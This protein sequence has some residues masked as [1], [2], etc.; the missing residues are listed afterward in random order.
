MYLLT[1]QL[2]QN[3]YGPFSKDAKR[4]KRCDVVTFVVHLD[5]KRSLIFVHRINRGIGCDEQ[6]KSR[7]R[8]AETV[9]DAETGTRLTG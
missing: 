2:T 8:G 3:I 4:A 6:Q 1:S 9:R 5:E 7:V